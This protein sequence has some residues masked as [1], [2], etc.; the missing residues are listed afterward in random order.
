MH[1]EECRTPIQ[2]K[3]P[4][5]RFCSSKCRAAAWQAKQRRHLE[6][7]LAEIEQAAR[8]IRRTL[9]RGDGKDST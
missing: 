6:D 2:P 5:G 7:A 4:R 1:C 9:W 8:S 3:H